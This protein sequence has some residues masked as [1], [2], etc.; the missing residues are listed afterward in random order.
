MQRMLS[1]YAKIEPTEQVGRESATP[2]Q[3][4]RKKKMSCPSPTQL[5]AGFRSIQSAQTLEKLGLLTTR[6]DNLRKA[7]ASTRWKDKMV[8]NRT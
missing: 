5:A 4:R 8:L 7:M 2:Q 6:S 3:W 1:T